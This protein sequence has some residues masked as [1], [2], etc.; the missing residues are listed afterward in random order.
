[1]VF[2]RPKN[3]GLRRADRARAGH[4]APAPDAWSSRHPARPGR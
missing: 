1:M 2:H 4:F 3:R